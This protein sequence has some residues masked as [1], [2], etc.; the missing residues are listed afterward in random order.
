MAN[1]FQRRS[2][3]RKFIY[4]GLILVLFSASYLLRHQVVLGQADSLA[5]R[6]QS[7]G[8]VELTSSAVRLSL[9][10]FKGLATCVLWVAA[11]DKQKRHEWNELEMLVK[12]VAKLQPHFITPWLFQSWNMSFNVTAECD[13]PH[14]KYFFIA[15]GIQ[16]LAEGERRNRGRNTRDA[17]IIFPGNPDLRF[18]LGLYYQLKIGKSDENR[19][20]RSLFQMSCMDPSERDPAKLEKISGGRREVNPAEFEKFCK[21][22]PRLVRRLRE[23]LGFDTPESI[24]AFLREHK[25]LPSRYEPNQG[26]KLNPMDRY[27]LLPPTFSEAKIPGD[28][29]PIAKQPRGEDLKDSFDNFAASREWYLFAMEPLPPPDPDFGA[30]GWQYDV[31]RHRLPRMSHYIFRQYPAIAQE[32]IALQLSQE[33]WFGQQGWTISSGGVKPVWFRD[34]QGEE[35]AVTVAKNDSHYSSGKAFEDAFESVKQ[36]G[37]HTGLIMPEADPGDPQGKRFR[38]LQRKAK[39]FRALGRGRFRPADLP[40]RLAESARANEILSSLNHNRTLTNFQARYWQLEAE[41]DPRAVAA[42]KHYFDA[43]KLWAEGERKEAIDKYVQ[44]ITIW[45][46][47]LKKKPRYRNNELMQE[48]SYEQQLRYMRRFQDQEKDK[49]QNLFLGMVS[50]AVR[51]PMLPLPLIEKMLKKKILTREQKA[52]IIPTKNIYGPFD[53][54]ETDNPEEPFFSP[55]IIQRVRDKILYPGK[56]RRRAPPPGMFGMQGRPPMNPPQGG[57]PSPP[58]DK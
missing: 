47:L 7:Q 31:R 52:R 45:K 55:H 51:P 18:H 36:F 42:H 2:R 46:E 43:E 5:L 21:Y 12:S 13:S 58:A 29:E 37:T 40:P 27:P 48:D 34:D 19:T 14:D 25:D 33:G 30:G 24:V 22:H 53:A 6:E 20:L 56:K 8:E 9:T 49:L 39:L 38:E 35:R 41:K 1:P 4:G 16:L 50:F 32:N 10:G 54:G 23:Q 28:D 44:W 11:Q 3:I 57:M 17:E 26:L 15:R